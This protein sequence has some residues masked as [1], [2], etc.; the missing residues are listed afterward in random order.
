MSVRE[1][2]RHNHP[3]KISADKAGWREYGVADPARL[4]AIAGSSPVTVLH[5]YAGAAIRW[6][7]HLT[8]PA[9]LQTTFETFLRSGV[10]PQIDGGQDYAQE[11]VNA[12]PQLRQYYEVPEEVQALPILREKLWVG[13]RGLKTPL[14]YDA[15]ETLHWCLTGQKRFRLYRPGHRHMYSAGGHTPFISLIDPDNRNQLRMAHDFPVLPDVDTTLRAGEVLYLPAYW[16]HRVVSEAD[17]NISLNFVWHPSLT[18][19]L[20]NPVAWLKNRAHVRRQIGR[21]RALRD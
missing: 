13:G 9:S 12:L 11:D 3:I 17:V 21:S 15:V 5:Q 14:H 16:W 8:K 1:H 2:V 18:R 6:D 10:S 4:A 20:A 19:R 7:R